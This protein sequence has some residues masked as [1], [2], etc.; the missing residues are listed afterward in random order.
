MEPHQQSIAQQ[1]SIHDP[2]TYWH[3]FASL[4]HWDVPYSKVLTPAPP[5][6]PM[7]YTW[8]KDGKL[9]TCFNAIDRHVLQGRGQQVAIY[10]DSPVSKEKRAITFKELLNQVQ[11]CAGLIA[12]HG[13]K[14][15]DLVLIYMPMVPEALVSML[16]CARLG[17]TH[18]VVFGGFAPLEIKKRID[19]SKPKLIIGGSCGIEVNRIVPYKAMLDQAIDMSDHKP[20][21]RVIFQREA[22][23]AV[24]DPARGDLDWHDEMQRIR[25]AGKQFKEYVPVES[26][27]PLY[28]L[29]T[30]G[31]TGL[32]KGVVRDNGGHATQTMASMINLFGSKPGDV[33]FCASDVGWVV[34]HSFIC[35]GPLLMGCSTVLY[36]GKP[37]GTPDAGAFFR[38]IQEYKVNTF[39]T[40]PTALRAVRRE[41]PHAKLSAQYDL[42]SLT[43]LFLAGERSDKGTIDHFRHVIGG[44][45]VVDNYW[46]TE[47]GSPV[48]G[49]CQGLE[50]AHGTKVTP[51]AVRDGSAGMP[52]P[53]YDVRVLTEPEDSATGYRITE[54]GPNNFGNLVIKLPLPPSA[55]HTLWNNPS[56]FHKSYLSR[57]PGY[58]DTG[59]AG[60]ID[61]DGYVHI[62]SRTDDIMQVAGHRM[63]TGSVEQ[64]LAEHPAVSECCVVPLSDKLKGQV[65]MG[66]IV[67]KSG[68]TES[69]EE[70]K[71]Q[72]TQMVRNNLGAIANYNQTYV[73]HRLPKTRSGKILRRTIRDIIAGKSLENKQ[74][75]VPATIEDVTVLNELEE[76]MRKLGLVGNDGEGGKEDDTVKPKDVVDAPRAKL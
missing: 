69:E 3:H 12:S 26:Q 38:I 72:V 61:E 18:S 67:L 57:F 45:P 66:L 7:D 42:R 24:L 1:I 65:P 58:Y 30:S 50:D 51:I 47:S 33:M 31:T 32:P 71:K 8:F 60:I 9:N 20:A 28:I 63:S 56:G 37:I 23:R 62:M 48:T 13:V 10:Y 29:Y 19:D 22:G 68:V 34:G 44:K 17:V 36:E 55:L 49:A 6:S 15:G 54:L 52:L 4:L 53:G 11:T 5:S 43:G 14:K 41:D 76:V 35:Y 40:A 73:V 46:S 21:Y 25:L 74:L 16:A 39:F 75:V 27:H 64:I 59:D 70:I 2:D